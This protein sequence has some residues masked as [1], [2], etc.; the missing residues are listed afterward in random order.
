MD[1]HGILENVFLGAFWVGLLLTL[2]MAAMSGAFHHEFG[3]GSAFEGGH[4]ADLGGPDVEGGHFDSGHANVGWSDASF[5]GASPLSPT[6]ICSALTGFGGFGYLG[7]GRW[8]LGVGGSLALGILTSLALG[9]ATFFAMDWLFRATQASSHISSQ[10][11]VGTKATVQAPIEPHQ[12]GS[13]V[14]EAAGTR[15]SVPARS[16]DAAPV[17]IGAEVEIKRCDG[18]VYVVEETRESWLARGRAKPESERKF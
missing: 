9:T 18:G 1:W 4:A 11:L 12:A 13:I 15:M 16:V 17:P 5:P 6:V 7:L 3:Q 8:E 14:L 10:G 2:V